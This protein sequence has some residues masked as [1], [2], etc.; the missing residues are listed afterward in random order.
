MFYFRRMW[1]RVYK[2]V[3]LRMTFCS[4]KIICELQIMLNLHV[5]IMTSRCSIFRDK[6]VEQQFE[7]AQKGIYRLLSRFGHV[8][9]TRADDKV[10]IHMMQLCLTDL[11]Q[12]VDLLCHSLAGIAAQIFVSLLLLT[13]N[14]YSAFPFRTG[15]TFIPLLESTSHYWPRSKTSLNSTLT[16]VIKRIIFVFGVCEKIVYS[17]TANKMKPTGG[18]FRKSNLY[19]VSCL[20]LLI[21]FLNHSENE[22]CSI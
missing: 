11:W 7:T 22:I 16:F 14:I 5:S 4:S 9:L 6:Y 18:K 15:V 2:K 3:N 8:R 19:G 17:F 10:V 12:S 13:L 1:Q 21:L 20:A